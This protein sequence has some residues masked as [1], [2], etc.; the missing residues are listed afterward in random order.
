MQRPKHLEK[1]REVQCY[2]SGISRVPKDTEGRIQPLYTA[3]AF[4]GIMQSPYKSDFVLRK[5][6]VNTATVGNS[7][8]AALRSPVPVSGIIAALWRWCCSTAGITV[9]A[10]R[11][12][13]E[14]LV[15]GVFK[16]HRKP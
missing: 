9:Q 6:S 12:L 4:V 10:A 3:L 5:D 15:L 11:Q 16:L 1:Y 14:L 2:L 7:L 13:P 8:E